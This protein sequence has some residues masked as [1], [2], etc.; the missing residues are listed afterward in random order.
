MAQAVALHAVPH[1]LGQTTQ[2]RHENISIE[3]MSGHGNLKN[4]GL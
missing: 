1:N 3:I 4:I 2:S